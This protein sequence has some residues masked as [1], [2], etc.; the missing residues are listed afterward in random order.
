[1]DLLVHRTPVGGPLGRLGGACVNCGATEIDAEGFCESCGR[2]QPSGRD[3]MEWDLGGVAGVGDRGRQRARNEDS[4]AL[5]RIG[6]ADAVT[7]GWV[8]DSRAYWISTGGETPSRALTIDDTVAAQLVAAGMA[9]DDAAR[10]FNAHA[11]SAWIGADAG[12]VRP[13]VM[14]LSPVG[15]GAL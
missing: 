7:V 4:M 9:E 3:R 13:H 6:P 2:S 14:T 12:E 8:G 15:P 5:A 11:L 1:K 10:V